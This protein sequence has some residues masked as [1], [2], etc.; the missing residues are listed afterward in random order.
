MRKWRTQYEMIK[1]GLAAAI[2]VV[3]LLFQMLPFFLLMVV[4]AYAMGVTGGAM[5]VIVPVLLFAMMFAACGLAAKRPSLR[6]GRAP[7]W[8]PPKRRQG[9]KRSVRPGAVAL[10]KTRAERYQELR[11][12]MRGAWW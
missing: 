4:M 5:L 3:A 8:P 12:V 7:A 1:S 6:P 11:D 9:R 10:L 2:L